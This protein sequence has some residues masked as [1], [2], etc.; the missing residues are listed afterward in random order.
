M[1]IGL[2]STDLFRGLIKP[3]GWPA[4]VTET[5]L[6]ERGVKIGV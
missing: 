6:K 3:E 5:W 1:S 4:G 2:K